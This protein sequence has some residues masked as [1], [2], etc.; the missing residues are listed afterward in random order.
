VSPDGVYN[1]PTGT[2]SSRPSH[3]SRPTDGDGDNSQPI[4][5]PEYPQYPPSRPIYYPPFPNA[6]Q[7]WDTRSPFQPGWPRG[8]P[9]YGGNGSNNNDENTINIRVLLGSNFT[10][11]STNR[12]DSPR[13][14][15]QNTLETSPTSSGVLSGRT[16][17]LRRTRSS[18]RLNRLSSSPASSADQSTQPND[19][20]KTSNMPN[21]VSKTSTTPKG[22]P[23]SREL[24][25]SAMYEINNTPPPDSIRDPYIVNGH[26]W[27]TSSDISGYE[28]PPHG[29]NESM[30]PP[31][32]GMQPTRAVSGV[33]RRSTSQNGNGYR[34]RFS[35]PLTSTDY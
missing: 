20:S 31:S 6:G 5:I 11:G 27:R 2:G 26:N 23:P 7:I 22:A 32:N 35:Y 25:A 18:E 29:V 17:S 8:D 33:S 3:S 9:Y 13:L 19:I 24:D 21:D 14:K 4:Y 15:A 12:H 1:S 28:T 16:R 34:N 10:S 30:T